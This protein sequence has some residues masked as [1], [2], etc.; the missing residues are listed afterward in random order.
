MTT[1][2]P[3]P[4]INWL[5]RNRLLKLGLFVW[6][7]VVVWFGPNYFLFGKLTRLNPDDFVPVVQ[8]YCVPAVRA[9]KIYQRS[10]G[11]LPADNSDLGTA[12]DP[13]K[14]GGPGIHQIEANGY[15]Y[16]TFGIYMGHMV[17]YDFTPGR[18]GWSV[19]GA[20]AN[21]PVPVPPVILDSPSPASKNP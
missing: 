3:T 1:P 13:H 15:S 19:S 9:M 18:E 8:K 5:A 2:D 14:D 21:G 20:F 16:M 7:A 17:E 4:E 12:F 10:H 6:F 11:Q